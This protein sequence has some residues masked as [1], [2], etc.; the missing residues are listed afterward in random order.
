MG[1]EAYPAWMASCYF[2]AGLLHALCLDDLME[3]QSTAEAV[4]PYLDPTLFRAKGDAFYDD[5]DI[6]LI[7]HS[8]QRALLKRFPDFPKVH[9]TRERADGA[10]GED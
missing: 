5:R 7:L 6:V 3:L 10:Q 2:V 4:A 9:V 8:A 1:R